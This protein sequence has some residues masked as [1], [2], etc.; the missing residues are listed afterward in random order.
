MVPAAVLIS[1]AAV[2][3][4]VVRES[5]PRLLEVQHLVQ[6]ASNIALDMAGNVCIDISIVCIPTRVWGSDGMLVAT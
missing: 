2:I 5:R 3:K 1:R 4:D 6:T